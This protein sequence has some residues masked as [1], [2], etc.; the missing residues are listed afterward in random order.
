MT[1]KNLLNQILNIPEETQTIEFKRLNGNKVI[2][3]IIQTVVAMSNTDGG[4][5]FRNRRP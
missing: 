1:N 5:Y 4:T 2:G 3:K